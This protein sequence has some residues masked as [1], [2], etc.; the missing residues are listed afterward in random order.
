MIVTP[1]SVTAYV[2]VIFNLDNPF[3]DGSRELGSDYRFQMLASLN[4][5]LS[6]A[7]YN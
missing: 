6:H 5:S 2:T 7:R 3:M 1:T 4:L